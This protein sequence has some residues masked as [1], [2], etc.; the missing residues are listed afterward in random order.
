MQ[1]LIQLIA[2]NHKKCKECQICVIMFNFWKVTRAPQTALSNFASCPRVS[3]LQEF[4]LLTDC[5]TFVA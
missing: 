5:P 4:Y 2:R 3:M 1:H